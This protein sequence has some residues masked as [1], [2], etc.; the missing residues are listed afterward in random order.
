MK[1]I[2]V[3]GFLLFGFACYAK[4]ATCIFQSKT[5]NFT[6]SVPKKLTVTEVAKPMIKY[7]FRIGA[8][9]KGQ[10][11]KCEVPHNSVAGPL[12]TPKFADWFKYGYG[13]H[14][15][16]ECKDAY[17]EVPKLRQNKVWKLVL[18]ADYDGSATAT[19]RCDKS[20]KFTDEK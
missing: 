19:Y 17:A 16:D 6:D 1:N 9:V 13:P 2:V 12:D 8:S 7:H 18:I 15:L 3:T 11:K 14:E 20:P 4:Q 10:T 5:K